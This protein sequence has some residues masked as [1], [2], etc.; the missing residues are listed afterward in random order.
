MQVRSMVTEVNAALAD[1]PVVVIHGARQSGKT[2]LTRM[3]CEGGERRY[4]TLDDPTLLKSALDDAAG[5]LAGLRGPVV[6]DEVQRAPE[7]FAALKAEVDR[8]RRP[9]RFLLTGSANVLML[10]RLADSLAG[11][12]EILT[13]WPLS[14]GEMVSRREDFIDRAFGGG[15]LTVKGAK[16]KPEGPEGLGLLERLVKG[17]FPE[18]LTRKDEAR[19]SAWF[20]SY[21]TTI[22]QRDVRDLANIEGLTDLPRLLALIA[23]RVGGVLNFADLSRGLSI[24][25]T[26]MK[27]YFALLE[28]TFLAQTI[29]AWASNRG[30][31][32]TKA[33]KVMLT[34]TGLACHLLGANEERLGV[35]AN[36]RGALVE[37]F[38]AMEL[39]KQ[40]G[41]AKTKV[42]M[43][44]FRA[45]SGREVDIVLEDAAGNVVGI[46][47]KS[48]S[49]VGKQDF[50]GLQTLREV[51]GE[52]F[53]RGIVAYDGLE[54]VSFGSDVAVPIRGLWG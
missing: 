18:P 30:V 21:L 6:I 27:R 8:D 51:A 44:H 26:T 41:W 53:R 52:K 13:L 28:T 14:Q 34:D 16:G 46:E 10:P 54:T 37:N 23:T 5:F 49:T 31:R 47:V 19:R 4:L 32:L 11:R 1:T 40:M 48:S 33:P 45:V 43:Y 42:K 12:V 22:L 7:M 25:Q 17:G 9:G 3:M 38:V 2:T 20:S 35:D 15:D 24:P 39:L 29:P 36:A 50:V